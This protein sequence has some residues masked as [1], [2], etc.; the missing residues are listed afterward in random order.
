MALLSAGVSLGCAMQGRQAS[1]PDVAAAKAAADSLNQAFVAALAARDTGAVV[2]FYTDDARFLP[3]NAPR[4]DGRDAIRRSW[5]E[6]LS[7]PGLALE[8]RSTEVMMSEAGDMVVDIG[9]YR[10]RASGPGN[11]PMEDVGKYVVI[12]KRAEGRWKIAVDIFNSDL[13]MTA[14]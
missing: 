12:L 2:D 13:S 14:T 7:I 5:A 6:F 8:L 10:L 3:S 9:T 4:A 1:T 11:Q